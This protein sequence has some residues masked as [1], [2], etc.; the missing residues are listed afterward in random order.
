MLKPIDNTFRKKVQ[1][2]IKNKADLSDLI[3]GYDISELDLS[4]GVIKKLDLTNETIHDTS[5]VYC[6]L[7]TDAGGIVFNNAILTNCSF[8]D[9]CFPGVVMARRTQF[10][11]CSFVACYFPYVDYCYAKFVRCI[12]CE[13]VF[14]I[15]ARQSLGAE[16]DE[17]FFGVL[18]KY[19]G[20]KVIKNDEYERLKELEKKYG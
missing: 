9:A 3:R 12:F 20:I 1:Y 17:H 8:M 2:A 18:H 11:G 14:R 10:T 15:G 7:G 6:Q 5:F 19:M 4:G 13:A 16:F